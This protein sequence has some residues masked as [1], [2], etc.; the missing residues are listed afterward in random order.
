VDELDSVLWSIRTTPNRSTD[1]TPFFLVYG[2]E[3]VPLTDIGHDSP[4]VAAYT[5]A[6]NEFATQVAKHLLD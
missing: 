3:V 2:A 1:Y 4:R 6:G 5:E